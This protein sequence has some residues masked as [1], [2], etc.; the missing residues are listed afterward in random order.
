MPQHT[1]ILPKKMMN[2][3][4]LN[5]KTIILNARRPYRL[6]VF[7]FC[8]RQAIFTTCACLVRRQLHLQCKTISRFPNNFLWASPPVCS[9]FTP[10]SFE[11]ENLVNLKPSKNNVDS[12]GSNFKNTWLSMCHLRFVRI[13]RY[14]GKLYSRHL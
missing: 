8:R 5:V 10:T 9:S 4:F 14:H 13:T 12:T 1:Y 7:P 11:K 2:S 6:R 3:T